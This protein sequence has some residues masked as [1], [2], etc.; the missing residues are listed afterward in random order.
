MLHIFCNINRKSVGFGFLC[1]LTIFYL[2][3]FPS[4]SFAK[5]RELKAPETLEDIKL[6][7]SKFVKLFPKA[8]KE[9]WQEATKV[10]QKL[11][12]KLKEIWQKFLQRKFKKVF[13]FFE[14]QIQKRRSIFKKELQKEIEETKKD[15]LIYLKKIFKH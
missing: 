5:E 7:F 15:I 4:F 8:L 12:L 1:F 14:K 11:Y 10:W 2:A 3:I 9:S 6:F 13:L